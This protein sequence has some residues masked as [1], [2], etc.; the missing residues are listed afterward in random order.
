MKA[1]AVSAALVALAAGAL[2]W[3]VQ[4]VATNCDEQGYS[5]CTEAIMLGYGVILL[6]AVF[7]CLV[8][9]MLLLWWSRSFR[10]TREP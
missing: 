6:V 5:E 10:E 9:A 7:L 8:V 1:L 3:R 4:A 2:F